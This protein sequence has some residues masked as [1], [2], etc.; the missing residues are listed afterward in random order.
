MKK[1]KKAI[2]MLF[3][4]VMVLGVTACSGGKSATG[5]AQLEG[6]L[7]EI[8]AQIY[9][10]V[11][12]ELPEMMTQEVNAENAEFF[13]GVNDLKFDEALASEPMMS[14]QAHSI[15]LLRASEGADIE[16]MKTKI[17]ENVD[18]RKWIC[19][20]VD[21]KNVITDNAGDLV[22]L[23]MDDN[24]KAFHDSFLSLVE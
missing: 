11:D 2:L 9:S 13:L 19:V 23:I 24:S 10:G 18:N 14:S 20:E 17:K 8:M 15:V 4:G 12:L 7:E 6:T 21:E 16:E 5:G 3:L 1:M 22:I